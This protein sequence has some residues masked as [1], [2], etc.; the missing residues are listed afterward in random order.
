MG[1]KLYIGHWVV[2]LLNWDTAEHP[3]C[4]VHSC[5]RFSIFS[6]LIHDE[7]EQVVKHICRYLIG[8]PDKSTILN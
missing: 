5:A 8:T 1:L 2:V 3:I 6:K 7:Q 4:R